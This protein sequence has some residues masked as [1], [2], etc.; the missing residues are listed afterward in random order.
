MEKNY[1]DYKI[2]VQAIDDA[3]YGKGYE[4]TIYVPKPDLKEYISVLRCFDKRIKNRVQML[5]RAKAYIDSM[6]I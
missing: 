4:A 5:E 6:S 2:I 3:F 1:K